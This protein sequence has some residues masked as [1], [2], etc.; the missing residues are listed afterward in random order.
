MRTFCQ[1][2]NINWKFDHSVSHEVFRASYRAGKEKGFLTAS[3]FAYGPMSKV[4]NQIFS[5]LDKS[6]ARK[7]SADLVFNYKNRQL[8]AER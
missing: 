6:Y 4:F 3:N 7:F 5:Q 8:G 1:F 2:A